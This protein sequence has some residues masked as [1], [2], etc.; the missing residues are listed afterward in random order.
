[1]FQQD[2]VLR[3]IEMLVQ[4]MARTVFHKDFIQYEIEDE[5]N[6]TD[7]DTLYVKLRKLIS[8]HRICEAEDLLYENLDEKNPAY[9]K[10]ALDFYQT[11]NHLTDEELEASNF[12]RQEINDGLNEILSRLH[13]VVI[14]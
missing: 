5:T 2:W 11:I 1:M 7:T 3:Q 8:E 6:L 9:L 4:F 10:L 14:P 12:S 13:Q